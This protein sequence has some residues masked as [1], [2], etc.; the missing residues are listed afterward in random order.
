VTPPCLLLALMPHSTTRASLKRK[1]PEENAYAKVY[2][3]SKKR[4]GND[5]N[6]PDQAKKSLPPPY[7]V[8]KLPPKTSK[9][10]ISGALAS[11]V[12]P[13]IV[14][15]NSSDRKFITS[16]L[17]KMNFSDLGLNESL[18]AVIDL[19]DDP[20][21]TR[22]G[23]CLSAS[24]FETFLELVWEEEGKSVTINDARIIEF[25]D[26]FVLHHR[27]PKSQVPLLGPGSYWALCSHVKTYVLLKYGIKIGNDEITCYLKKWTK[28]HKVEKWAV[29]EFDEIAGFVDGICEETVGRQENLIVLFSF[30]LLAHSEETV[31]ITC[32]M[33]FQIDEE[34]GIVGINLKCCNKNPLVTKGF[35][36]SVG[37]FNVAKELKAHLEDLPVQDGHL[38]W[39]PNTTWTHLVGQH[40]GKKQILKIAK[41]ITE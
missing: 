35:I 10:S 32:D 22:K 11:K 21:S 12:E 13:T 15:P 25:F 9:P 26:C 19:R 31:K 14:E 7:K 18:Q 16:P 24:H 38:W 30:Y 2:N 4:R 1:E 29:F 41:K 6:E 37:S 20:E 39:Q 17:K 40:M 36:H 34:K 27:G 23:F 8:E 5:E 33:I 28:Y 3:S